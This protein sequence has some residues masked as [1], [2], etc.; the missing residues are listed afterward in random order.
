MPLETQ[1]GLKNEVTYGTAVT[2]DRFTEYNSEK[3]VANRSRIEYTGLRAGQRVQR[4]D[5]FVPINKGAS[6]PIVLNPLSV[7]WGFWLVHMLGTVATGSTADSVTPHTATIGSLVGDA[8]TAQ[9]N[10]FEAGTAT[11]RAFTWEGGKVASWELANDVDGLLTA[12]YNCDFEDEKTGTALAS[13][14][15]PSGGE[16]FSWAGGAVTI[17]GTGTPVTGVKIGCD[18]G[19]KLDRHHIRG[20]T[21]KRQPVENTQRMITWELTPDFETLVDYNRFVSNTAA[22]ALATIVATWTAPTL[23]GTATYPIIQV[24]IDNAR[25]DAADPSVSGPE[26]LMNPMSGRGLFDGTDSAI[27]IVYTTADATP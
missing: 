6:G 20:T 18:N 27:T 17:A 22:G 3:I 1:L 26:M 14:S 8:F 7:G 21:L 4:S 10:R 23:V 9:A 13:A 24:T 5:R 19:Q 11:N 2:V 16:L 15:Y 25:F 12:T